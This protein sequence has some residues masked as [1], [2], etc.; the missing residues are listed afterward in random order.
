MKAIINGKKLSGTVTVPS[1]KSIVHRMLICAS[2][3]DAPTEIRFFGMSADITA[4]ADCIRSLGGGVETTPDGFRV[5]PIVSTKIGEKLRCRESGTTLRLLLP[6]TAALGADAS[7]MTEGRLADRPLSPLD[8]LMA[9]HGCTVSVEGRVVSCSGR[10]IGKDFSID[11]GVSSQ[12]VSGLLL[13]LPILGGGSVTVTGKCESRGYIDMTVA[14]MR[15][16]GV[17]VSVDGGTY[18]VSGKYTSPGALTAEGDWSSA[19]FWAVASALGGKITL[20]G[21][22][23]DS[24]QGDRA[25]LRLLEEM[26]ARVTEDEDGITVSADGGLHTARFD[27]SDIPDIVPVMTAAALSADGITEIHGAARLRLKESDR[28]ASTA[29]MIASCGGCVRELDDGLEI[30]GSGRL[31]GGTV[32]AC[33]DHRIAMS[34]AVLSILCDGA[35][36]IDGAE[37]VNKSYPDFWKDF[38]AL[39]GDVSLE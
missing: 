37:N 26:G 19:A 25:V 30:T 15:K 35:V 17:N 34:A 5:T 14:V 18:T 33:G 4:A 24:L 31:K 23:T 22:N 29:Q 1:S 20:R 16:F 13:T 39:G 10:L 9:E 32:D 21:M 7:F 6:V 3:A 28:I 27:A 8:S 38:A 36:T 2:L 12:F 11:G